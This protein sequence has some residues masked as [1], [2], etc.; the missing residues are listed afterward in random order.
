MATKYPSAKWR[1]IARNF[2]NRPRARTRGVILHT[3]ASKTAT[4]MFGWFS[5]LLAK[6]SSHVHIADDGTIEQYVDLDRIAWT[7]GAASNTTIGIETQGDGTDPWTPAQLAALEDFLVYVCRRYKIPARMMTSSR[8]SEK[9]IGWHRLGID[10]NFPAAGIL[11]GRNQRGGGGESWSSS[12]RKVCPG[13]KRIEQIPALVAA[14][15]ARL[16]TSEPTPPAKPKPATKPKPSAK[17]DVDG[18]WGKD[19][20]TRTQQVVGS[21]VDGKVSG[22]ERQHRQPGLTSGWEWNAPGTGKGSQLIY[23]LQVL[24]KAKGLYKGKLDGIAGP[25]FWTAFQL[26]L[27]TFPDGEIWAKSP[28]I[29]QFQRN[30]NEGKLW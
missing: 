22:Q 28:A 26:A 5:N 29:K 1:P 15:D 10:G 12:R 21:T 8:S 24:L 27:G 23:R 6:A 25:Q 20:T 14:V 11:R 18:Y 2:T 30:L 16:A 17:L 7:T 3:T 19:V 9:G 13:D 4:S